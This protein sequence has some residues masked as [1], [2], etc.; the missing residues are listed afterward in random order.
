MPLTH[1]LAGTGHV[2]V[3]L[4]SSVCDRRMWGPQV[5]PLLA[6][7]HRVLAPDFRGYGH[8]PPPTVPAGDAQDVRDLLDELGIASAAFVGSSYGGRIA[9]EFAARW[10]DRVTALALLCA[11]RAG[12]PPTADVRAFGELEDKL[13]EAGDLDGAVALNVRTW[14]GPAAGTETRALVAEMQRHAFEVQLAAPDVEPIRAEYDLA[15]VTAPT[16]VVSGAHDLDHFQETAEYLAA[17]IPGARHEA[18]PWAGHLPSLEDP[19]RLNPLLLE[20][21]AA[22]R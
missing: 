4:H 7:G 12:H 6:A 5:G 3:L 18:L 16:L 19:A 21:L 1:D 10:P 17:A 14:L 22:T 15:A 13:I 11:G 2:A 9:Q 8:T 20:F